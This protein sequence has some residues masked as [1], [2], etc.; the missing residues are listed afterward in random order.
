[1]TMPFG[2]HRRSALVQIPTSYLRW[3]LTIRICQALA[4]AVTAEFR[5]RPHAT[6]ERSRTL[7]PATAEMADALGATGYRALAKHHHPDRGGIIAPCSG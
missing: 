7:A 4:D 1:M 2:K 5:R 6:G 3:L